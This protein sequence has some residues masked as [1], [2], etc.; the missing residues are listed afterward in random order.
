MDRDMIL[1]CVLC[2]FWTAVWHQGVCFVDCGSR[3]DRV[4]T[5]SSMGRG[6]TSG[7]VMSIIDRGVTS[8]C[9]LCRLWTAVWHQGVCCVAD[10]QHYP[11][12]TCITHDSITGLCKPNQVSCFSLF[13]RLYTFFLSFQQFITISLSLQQWLR[14]FSL[15]STWCYADSVLLV[16]PGGLVALLHRTYSRKFSLL[17]LKV[18]NFVRKL[19]LTVF[20]IADSSCNSVSGYP[21]GS[22]VEEVA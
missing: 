6:V 1:G 18:T 2:R 14:T 4:C 5:V 19:G 3:C 12:L 7:Y 15:I 17:K 8:G 11:Y 16:S 13:L 20:S 10:E 21:L 22:P 9:V